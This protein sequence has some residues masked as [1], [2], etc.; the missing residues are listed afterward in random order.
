MTKYKAAII[1]GGHI[2][3]QNHI[4]ALKALKDR[5]DIL[6]VSSRDIHKA[7]AL[8]D[9]HGIPYAYDNVGEMFNQEEKPNVIINCTANHLHYSYTMQ[10]LHNNCH[11]LCEKPPAMNAREAREMAELAQEKGLTLAYN[12]QRRQ[13]TEYLLLK[14]Y[15]EQLGKIYHVKATYLRRRGIPGWGNFTNKAIQGGGALIDLGVHVLDLALGFTGY[16]LPNKILANSYDAIGKAGGKGLKGVWDPTKFEVE[17]ASF[18]YLSFPNNVSLSLSCSFALNMKE[19]ETVNLE[20]FGEKGGAT[21]NPLSIHTEVGGEL[22]D[23]N[24]PFIQQNN[25]QQMN[26]EGFLDLCDGKPSNICNAQEGAVIQEIVEKI[27]ES[28][29]QSRS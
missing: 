12:F 21:L 7:R 6:A 25:N 15:E 8:A 29:D 10:A 14:K 18:S 4:P 19:A 28:A 20:I 17:D 24:F 16:Q 1:G 23:I 13:S 9:Q 5:V 22:A 26:T 27:Y 11:V 3:N 2:A